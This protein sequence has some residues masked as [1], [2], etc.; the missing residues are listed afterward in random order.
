M[1]IS[2]LIPTQH[3]IRNPS[4][5]PNMIEFITN[6]GK[7]D[8]LSLMNYNSSNNTNRN[9]SLIILNQFEDGQIYIQDGHHRIIAIFLAERDFLYPDEYKIET[10][11]YSEYTELTERSI[12]SNWLTPFD[13]RTHTRH[14]EFHNY[15]NQV[16]KDV[17][18][19]KIFIK[20]AWENNVYCIP[21]TIHT[22]EDIIRSL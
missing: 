5:I 3:S 13:P 12:K 19:A 11:T 22:I 6:N 16:P 14:A 7:F 8:Y 15:K 1:K 18:L 2:S 10:W 17:D 9:S 4:I 20:H 21:R